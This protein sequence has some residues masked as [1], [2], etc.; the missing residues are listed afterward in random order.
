MNPQLKTAHCALVTFFLTA[1]SSL[2]AQAPPRI[3]YQ[4]KLIRNGQPISG[5]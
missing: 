4:G 1:A 3:N 2:Q 5:A